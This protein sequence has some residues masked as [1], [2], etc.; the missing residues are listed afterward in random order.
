[1]KYEDIPLNN[2]EARHNFEMVVEGE[3]AFID[4][5]LRGDKI[6]LIHTE[7]PQAL[8]GKGIASAMVQKAMHYMEDHHLKIVPLCTYVQ[9][10]LKR[11]PEWNKLVA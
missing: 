6:Y 10:F 3:R 2:N 7:V 9:H 11:Y 8:E 5:Q 4:Y 1:M